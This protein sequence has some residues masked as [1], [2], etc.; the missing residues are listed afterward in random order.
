MLV[1][2]PQDA[3][4]SPI[5]NNIHAAD[6]PIFTHTSVAE[7]ADDKLIFASNENPIVASQHLQNHLNDMDVWYTKQKIKINSKNL[8][9]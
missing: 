7:F 3:I 5:L 8:H 2:V 4:W 9:I 6:Q 1:S